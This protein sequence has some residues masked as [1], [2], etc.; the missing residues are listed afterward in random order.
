MS[1]SSANSTPA[2]VP[3][4]DVREI[5]H[6]QRHPF[7]FKSYEELRPGQAFV[8]VVD[9]DPKPVFFELDF[10]QKGKFTWDYLEQG[11]ELW[12]VQIAKIQ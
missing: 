9:H 7:I 1:V 12:R 2:V 11:P 5:P 3:T 10:V 6:Q 8:L 4:V